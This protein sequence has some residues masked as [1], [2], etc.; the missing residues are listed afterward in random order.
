[1]KNKNQYNKNCP[2][3]AFDIYVN[4]QSK[5]KIPY[6]FNF[7]ETGYL[8]G[9]NDELASIESQLVADYLFLRKNSR[10]EK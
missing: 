6:T 2:D 10:E 3:W 5:G 9:D 1:M 4:K 7:L 8:I